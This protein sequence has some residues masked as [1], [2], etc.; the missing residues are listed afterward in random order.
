MNKLTTT[1]EIR[2]HTSGIVDEAT[3]GPAD[4]AYAW[5]VPGSFTF[6]SDPEIFANFL[7][8][9]KTHMVAFRF[10]INLN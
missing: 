7:E 3:G 9:V 4:M 10:P 5:P 1:M 8:A 2:L 6:D